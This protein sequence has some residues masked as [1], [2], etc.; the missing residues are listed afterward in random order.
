MQNWPGVVRSAGIEEAPAVLA[1]WKREDWTM[2][3]AAR[4]AYVERYVGFDDTASSGRVLDVI[5]RTGALSPRV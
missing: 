3:A 1:G 2:G 4:R 5:E